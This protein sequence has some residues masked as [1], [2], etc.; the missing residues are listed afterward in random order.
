[1]KK[2]NYLKYILKLAKN[3]SIVKNLVKDKNEQRI[4]NKK[5][6]KE[7]LKAYKKVDREIKK[8]DKYDNYNQLDKF[9]N[10]IKK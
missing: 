8:L 5:F 9:L 10:I 3:L 2:K 7:Y 4:N 6:K 1:M